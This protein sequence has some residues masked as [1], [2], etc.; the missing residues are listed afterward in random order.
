[1]NAIQNYISNRETYRAK[2][3][4]FLFDRNNLIIRVLKL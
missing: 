2:Y 1:M 3:K 4:T